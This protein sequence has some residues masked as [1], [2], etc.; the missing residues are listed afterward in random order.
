MFALDILRVVR[1]DFNDFFIIKLRE[2]ESKKSVSKLGICVEKREK[3]IL[4][5]FP[6]S[7]IIL[8]LVIKKS[9]IRL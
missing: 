1:N 5:L 9:F 6:V 8:N 4:K 2:R 3:L 7:L